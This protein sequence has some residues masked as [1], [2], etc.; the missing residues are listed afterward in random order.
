MRSNTAIATLLLQSAQAASSV[1]VAAGVCLS[2]SLSLSLSLCDYICDYI[3][4]Y[5][6]MYICIYIY[7]YVHSIYT[8]LLSLLGLLAA[9]ALNAIFDAYAEDELNEAGVCSR[10]PTYAH[11][12]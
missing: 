7:I 5:M 12:C 8:L 6:Y 9:E 1:L 2:L 10:M 4:M 11:V 3:C